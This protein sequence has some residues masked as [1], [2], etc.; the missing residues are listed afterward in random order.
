MNE[1]IMKAIHWAERVPFP[2]ITDLIW[3]HTPLGQVGLLIKSFIHYLE[4]RSLYFT[5]ASY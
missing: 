5:E 3:S 4:T 1:I 2:V